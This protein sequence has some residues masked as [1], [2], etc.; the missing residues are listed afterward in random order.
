MEAQTITRAFIF[1]VQVPRVIG[2]DAFQTVVE[3]GGNIN[4]IGCDTLT[5]TWL[6]QL[7]MQEVMQLLC[8]D[9][10]GNDTKVGFVLTCCQWW[11]F[12]R[13]S[14]YKESWMLIPLQWLTVVNADRL[15][16]SSLSQQY[17]IIHSSE[18]PPRCHVWGWGD[19]WIMEYKCLF[20]PMEA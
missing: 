12:H 11:V 16:H 4:D 7:S 18:L 5:Q 2:L 14:W 13:H 3:N 17:H 6:C 20:K 9:C 10:V 15:Q 8:G 1:F 19:R